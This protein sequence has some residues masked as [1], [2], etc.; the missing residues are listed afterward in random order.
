MDVERKV[1]VVAVVHAFALCLLL[2]RRLAAPRL[3]HR[4]MRKS[5]PL[6]HL[7][8]YQNIKKAVQVLGLGCLQDSLEAAARTPGVTSMDLAEVFSQENWEIGRNP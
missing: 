8:H 1:A 4:K 6:S 3:E 7:E 2:P 5:I